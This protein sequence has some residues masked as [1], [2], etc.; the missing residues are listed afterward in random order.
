MN[1]NLF[2]VKEFTIKTPPLSDG[3]LK[4][5]MRKQIMGLI[6]QLPDYTIEEVSISPF[7]LQQADE[8]FI[9]NVIAGIQPISNY[10]KKQFNN[11]IAKMLLQ[12]LQV[13]IRLSS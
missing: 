8:L 13:K 6:E 4:G 9:T 2:L 10:R 7:E 11:S 3:C 12:K 1:G 5:I